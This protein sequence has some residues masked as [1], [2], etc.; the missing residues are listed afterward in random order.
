VVAGIFFSK[1][2]LINSEATATLRGK[3]ENSHFQK[4]FFQPEAS[5]FLLDRSKKY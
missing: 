4:S 3:V 5:L 1:E 2:C